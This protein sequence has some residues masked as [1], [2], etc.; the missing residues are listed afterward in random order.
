MLISSVIF[1]SSFFQLKAAA[2]K[3]PVNLPCLQM[4]QL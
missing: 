1:I 2:L 3:N 4:F